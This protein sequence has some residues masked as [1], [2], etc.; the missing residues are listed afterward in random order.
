MSESFREFD[1]NLLR[2]GD[3]VVPEMVG[4]VHR[5]LSLEALRGVVLGT[6]VDA[7]R[8]R[9]NWQVTQDVPAAGFD[10]ERKDKAGNETIQQ[11]S[12]EV[13]NA[14][15]FT[16]SW[17]TN[18]VPYIEPLENGHSKQAPHGMARLT[19]ERLRRFVGRV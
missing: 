8:A 11:G 6:P 16:I 15:P 3:Q 9:G 18:N 4:K 14:K 12:A 19:I 5:A 7:G 2:F 13:G 10:A 1:R 17:I